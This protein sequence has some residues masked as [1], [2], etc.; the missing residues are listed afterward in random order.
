[1]SEQLKSNVCNDCKN[2]NCKKQQL[3]NDSKKARRIYSH[4]Q[5][6]KKTSLDIKIPQVE[7][8]NKSNAKKLEGSMPKK[9][10]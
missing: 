5:I 3:C 10:S 9:S 4:E 8:V 2:S 1:M 6:N 7:N